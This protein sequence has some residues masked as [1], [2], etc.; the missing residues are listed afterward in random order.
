MEKV[1]DLTSRE[2]LGRALRHQPLDHVPCC[3]MS[4]TA[5]RRRCHENMYELVKA[6]RAMGLERPGLMCGL[7][8]YLF[9]AT[10]S[11]SRWSLRGRSV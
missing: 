6:E 8:A 7:M 1:P 3:F 9:R 5:L 4:F 10:R 2:R 11:R